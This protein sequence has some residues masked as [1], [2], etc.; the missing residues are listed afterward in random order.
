MLIYEETIYT[1]SVGDSRAI[2]CTLQ[3]LAPLVPYVPKI[4]NELIAQLKA[5]RSHNY[6]TTLNCLQ[7]T[8]DQKPEDAEEFQ[9]II[10]RLFPYCSLRWHLALHGQ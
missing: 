8:K 4:D 10:R 7:L 9:R 6:D 2:L 1:A 3:E 5:T